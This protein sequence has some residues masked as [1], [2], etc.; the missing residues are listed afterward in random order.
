MA[1]DP[2]KYREDEDLSEADDEEAEEDFDGRPE[3]SRDEDDNVG[4]EEEAAESVRA[5]RRRN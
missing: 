1:R 3:Q 5:G 4:T 2:N